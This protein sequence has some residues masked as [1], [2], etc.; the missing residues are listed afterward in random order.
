MCSSL[1]RFAIMCLL[2]K[3]CTHANFCKGHYVVF[4]LEISAIIYGWYNSREIC[5]QEWVIMAKVRY[6]QNF[7]TVKL[8]NK[9]LFGHPK[10]VP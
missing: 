4:F 5:I 1:S 7:S 8:G 6:P 9:E 3:Y 10:I 2:I